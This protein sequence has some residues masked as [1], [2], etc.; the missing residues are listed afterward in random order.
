MVSTL[1]GPMLDVGSPQTCLMLVDWTFETTKLRNKVRENWLFFPKVSSGL[2]AAAP[3]VQ[4][5]I[6]LVGMPLQWVQGCRGVLGL[7]TGFSPGADH[8]TMT[9]FDLACGWPAAKSHDFAH[10]LELGRS[11]RN[12][13]FRLTRLA[14][15]R[16]MEHPQILSF[17]IVMLHGLRTHNCNELSS[18]C[19]SSSDEAQAQAFLD[20]YNVRASDVFSENIAIWWG[21]YSNVTDENQAA[22]VSALFVI[23]DL[24]GRS[25]K[26]ETR[27]EHSGTCEV[28]VWP[29]RDRIE[30]GPSS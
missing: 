11:G 22:A 6:P 10:G 27:V 24:V 29:S 26:K 23:Q 28:L 15:T 9:V 5:P 3:G 1:G 30:S 19:F 13:P 14:A 4:P 12:Q 18:F 16:K 8:S 25:L 21:Y 17:H 20:K 7:R 2:G